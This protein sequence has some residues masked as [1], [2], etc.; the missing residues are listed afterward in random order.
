MRSHE[1]AVEELLDVQIDHPVVSSNTAPGMP[2]RV[3]RRPS[4]PVAVGVRME[5][6]LDL[7]LQPAGHHRLRD[8]SATVGTPRISDPAAMR[9]RYLH[10]PHRRRKVAPRGHPIPDLV[11]IV[12]QIR[13]ELLQRA[14]VH[15]GAPLL[16]LT[17][18]DTPPT[19]PTS[20]YQTACLT[21][22]ARPSRLLPDDRLRLIERTQPQMTRPLRSTPTASSRGFT[23]TT[24]RSA[25]APRDGT[26]SLTVSA[27]RE[28]PLAA[29]RRG[30]QYRDAPSHVPCRSRRPGS[31]RLHAGHHLASK[32][33]PARLIPGLTYYTPVLMPPY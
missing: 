30:R 13:L 23:A 33:A 19:P 1:H 8:P 2:H 29:P 21:T 15:P 5:D 12:L 24:S 20:K 14:P 17:F 26:H 27:A 9:L 11:Q 22:S 18:S 32:R 6:R 7:R 16:A 3:Q 31:R 10:R 28:L 25:S 4:R